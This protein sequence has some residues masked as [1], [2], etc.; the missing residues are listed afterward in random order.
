MAFVNLIEIKVKP[1]PLNVLLW[2]LLITVLGTPL[3][4]ATVSLPELLAEADKNA[5]ANLSARKMADAASAD[6]TAKVWPDQPVVGAEYFFPAGDVMWSVQQGIPFPW[7]VL[8][9]LSYYKTAKEKAELMRLVIQQNT[10]AEVKKNFAMY[11][12]DKNKEKNSRATVELMRQYS[13]LANAN[14]ETGKGSA[15]ELVAAQVRIGRMESDRDM[16]E[17]EAISAREMLLAVLGRVKTEE[18]GDPVYTNEIP[19]V[20]NVSNFQIPQAP[21]VKIAQAESKQGV[22]ALS[23]AKAEWFPELMVG[24]K[25]GMPSSVMISASVPLFFWKQAAEVSRMKSES[26]AAKKDYEDI[27]NKTGAELRGLISRY[28]AARKK[29]VRYR[30]VIVPLS[31]QVLKLNVSSFVAGKGMF[32][33]ITMAMDQ[34]LKDKSEYYDAVAESR[35]LLADLERLTALNF[36]NEKR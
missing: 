11:W 36:E 34:Y 30:D 12:R 33:D 23:M 9:K 7:M 5:P 22:S 29:A 8:S 18:F 25:I 3:T 31:D 6:V 21:E 19:P 16:A 13:G 26:F 4:G 28:E 15:A 35:I 20:I 24:A 14:Y 10:A 32:N 2:L 1:K 17:S 27:L